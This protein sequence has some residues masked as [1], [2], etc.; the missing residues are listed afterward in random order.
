[1]VEVVFDLAEAPLIEAGRFP[2]QMA[3]HTPRFHVRKH[4]KS[5]GGRLGWLEHFQ[6]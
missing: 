2:A 5:R 4:Q 3:V 6:E 1:M